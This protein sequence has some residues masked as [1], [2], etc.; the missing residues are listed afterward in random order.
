MTLDVIL[1]RLHPLLIHLPIALILLAAGVEIVRIKR[2]SPT[3]GVFVVLLLATGSAGALAASVTG[4]IFAYEYYP[5]PSEQWMLEQHRWLGI[6]STT[7]AAMATVAAY[8]WAAVS[9]GKKVWLRRGI[10][11]LTA[12]TVSATAHFGAL[13]VWGADYFE[14]STH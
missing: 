14:I 13:M 8:R 1:G 6:S 5:P 4:W 3:L 9:A 11:W 7:L 10:I 2:D 12:I